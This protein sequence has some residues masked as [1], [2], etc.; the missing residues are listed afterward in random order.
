MTK[1]SAMVTENKV[2][3][4]W[5]RQAKRYDRSDKQFETINKV[6]FD[7]TIEYLDPSDNVLDFGCGTGS[8]TLKLA[9]MVKHVH[10]LD[11]SEEMIRDAEIKRGTAAASNCTFSHGTAFTADLAAGT[12]DTVISFSVIHLLKDAEGVI[13]R[14][15][16][17]LKPGGLF[18]STTVA[19]RDKMDLKYKF[20]FSGYRMLL[21]LGILPLHLNMLS[22]SDVEEMVAKAGF[23]IER[24]ERIPYEMA[25]YFLVARK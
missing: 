12:F 25:I 23:T 10:G 22:V 5:D 2:R 14:I 16:E 15:H 24:T 7:K 17:L 8:K 9:A 18:I 1:S 11:F 20:I 3:R 6:I 19:I 4:F 13:R 21:K